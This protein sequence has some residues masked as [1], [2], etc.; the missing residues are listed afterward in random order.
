MAGKDAEKI[1]EYLTNLIE[2]YSQLN[3]EMQVTVDRL[4][5]LKNVLQ[6]FLNYGAINNLISFAEETF[7]KIDWDSDDKEILFANR[8]YQ[9]I[10]VHLLNIFIANNSEANLADFNNKK[11]DF[12]R[13]LNIIIGFR[14][15]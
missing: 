1:I 10:L 11:E 12:Q 4:D 9:I 13:I 6:K 15:E 8:D 14:S 2:S 5:E 3:S 7:N